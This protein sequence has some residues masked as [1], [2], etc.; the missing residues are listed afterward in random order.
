[1]VAKDFAWRIIKR[2]KRY[3]ARF[4]DKVTMEV[5]G[6][7]S[8]AVIAKKAGVRFDGVAGGRVKDKTADE[9]VR[10]YHDMTRNVN[11]TSPRILEYIRE[12][13]NFDGER[14]TL[15]NRK[16]PNSIARNS[17]YTNLNNFENHMVKYFPDNPRIG[18]VT[19]R[20]LNQVQDD[21]IANSGLVNSTIEKVMRSV[22]TPLNDAFK[23][24]IID[25]GVRVD[26][27]NTDGK[28]KGILTKQQIA[29]VV[30]ELYA[31]QKERKG[32]HRGANEGI[33]LASLTA[34]R[35]GE[36]RA[37]KKEQ[38]EIVDETSIIHITRTWNNHD[39][40]KIPKGKRTRQVVIPTIVAESLI[41][42]ADKNPWRNGR[43]F[44]T[45]AGEDKVR[46]A[47]FFRD[48]LYKAMERAKISEKERKSKNITFHSLRHGYVSYLRHQVSDSTMRLVVGHRDKETTDIYTHLNM[49]NMK[50]LADTTNREFADIIEV[51]AEIKGRGKEKEE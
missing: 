49:E 43:V 3:Y 7:K 2:N 37:L 1:M 31:M 4:L 14:V 29:C 48:N 13:W 21:L 11:T 50:Q 6:E 25:N 12:Y 46:S 19:S 33:T 47:S 26:T 28:E 34:M 15:L 45:E 51:E 44:W 27:L 42:L 8:V 18:E 17:C 41:E 16:N 39:R 24:G 40:D 36:I 30:K 5:I 35:L 32:T 23:H 9:I 20:F 38:I 10:K 22:T